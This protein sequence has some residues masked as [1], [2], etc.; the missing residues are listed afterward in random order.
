MMSSYSCY[1]VLLLMEKNPAQLRM[2]QMLVL[3]QYQDLWGHRKWCR[4]FSIN[5][6]IIDVLNNFA[7]DSLCDIHTMIF[8]TV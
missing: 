7:I 6:M 8:D 3:Y 2:P 5:R 4:I 1:G